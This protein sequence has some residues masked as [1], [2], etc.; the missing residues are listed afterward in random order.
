MVQI[1]I[2]GSEGKP[3]LYAYLDGENLKFEFEYFGRDAYEGDY[4]FIHTVA[5][6]DFESLATKFG[7]ELVGGILAIVRQISD[8]GQGQALKRA[9]TDKEIKNDL[10]T[11]LS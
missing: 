8:L 11:W 7:L 6:E 9:L 1:P 2:I 5:P 4:E 10:W 3:I